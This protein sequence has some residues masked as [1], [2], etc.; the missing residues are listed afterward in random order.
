MIPAA[1][2]AGG[3]VAPSR[4]GSSFARFLPGLTEGQVS[5]VEYTPDP[6]IAQYILSSRKWHS[7]AAPEQSLPR[8]QHSVHHR[9]S[10]S[11]V[12]VALNHAFLGCFL[13]LYILIPYLD[14]LCLFFNRWTLCYC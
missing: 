1:A 4:P 2:P 8:K 7:E 5:Y 12:L 14:S 10:T 3:G 9:P 6:Q 13:V 11:N